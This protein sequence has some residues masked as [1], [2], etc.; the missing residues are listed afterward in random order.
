MASEFLID[1]FLEQ[2]RGCIQ[3][4]V[5][6]VFE[7]VDHSSPLKRALLSLISELFDSHL[8]YF[9]EALGAASD[10]I[11]ELLLLEG[12]YLC[13][14]AASGG[15]PNTASAVRRLLI[16]LDSL[17]KVLEGLPSETRRLLHILRE[18]LALLP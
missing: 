5:E 6:G 12:E 1:Q 15:D 7:S 14:P 17:D 10:L 8:G 9:Q 2:W 4:T 13:D 3:Q 16:F 11:V 18:L